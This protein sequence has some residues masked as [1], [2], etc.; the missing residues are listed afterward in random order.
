MIRYAKQKG[1]KDV[2][3]S[4]NATLLTEELSKKLIYAGLDTIQIS[5]E[6]GSKREYEMIREGAKFESVRKNISNFIKIRGKKT[7][8]KMVINLLVYKDTDIK[9]FFS[10]WKD[11]CDQILVSEMQPILTFDRRKK[12]VIPIYPSGIKLLDKS[13]KVI[14]CNLPFIMPV[15]SYDGKVGMCCSDFEF[16]LQMGDAKKENILDIFNNRRYRRVRHLFVFKKFD[17]TH[18]RN[19]PEIYMSKQNRLLIAAQNQIDSWMN[20]IKKV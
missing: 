9:N 14:G 5:V 20:N 11:F 3:I 13:R 1:I 6:G 18:C 2:S 15:I 12:C 16:V 17:K 7:K 19:C 4:T 10:T 8:P